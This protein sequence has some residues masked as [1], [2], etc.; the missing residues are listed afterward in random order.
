MKTKN[1]PLIF[2]TGFLTVCLFFL[3]CS[4]NKDEPKLQGDNYSIGDIAGDWTATEATFSSLENPYKGG[5]DIINEGGTLKLVI[6]NN[7]R[8]TFTIILPGEPDQVTTGQLG[9]DEEWLAV[10]YDDDPGEYDYLFFDLNADKSILTIRGNGGYDF[11]D[12]G[13]EDFATMSF[14]LE[15][16]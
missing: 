4:C 1:R 9:F 12:D 10:S 3:T 11:D 8:F 7:G 5:I 15:R 2:I 14:I 6:Q 13:T 16:D